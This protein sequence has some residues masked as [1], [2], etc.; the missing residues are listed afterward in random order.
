M[1]YE[2]TSTQLLTLDV[3]RKIRMRCNPSY[4][5]QLDRVVELMDDEA[6]QKQGKLELADLYQ[7]MR[8]ED[9]NERNI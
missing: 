3:A 1:S 9:G 6:S 7:R 2:P 5:L 8:A 4:L